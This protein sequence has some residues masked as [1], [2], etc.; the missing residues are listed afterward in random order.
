[1]TAPL[2]IRRV[3]RADD[4]IANT[5]IGLYCSAF[6]EPPYHER[7]R[8]EDVRRHTWERFCSA[9]LL[10]AESAGQLLGFACATPLIQHTDA[11]LL[12]FLRAQPDF[13]AGVEQCIYM[14]ELAVS[15]DA[16][17]RRVG[18]R[19]VDARLD[20]AREHGL[21]H[22]VMRTHPGSPS[23]RIY[24]KR[25]GQALAALQPVPGASASKQRQVVWGRVPPLPGPNL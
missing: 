9:C 11:S 15:S 12:Q 3:T 14:A 8:P 16:R 4:P 19:L 20:Y 10:V 22:F 2:Q 5:V 6:A 23:A 17:G 1:M 21:S 18:T 13:S 24:L 7:H 25:G